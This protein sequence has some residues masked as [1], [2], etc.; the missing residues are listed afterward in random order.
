VKCDFASANPFSPAGRR[1]RSRELGLQGR[2]SKRA[3]RP[4]GRAASEEGHRLVAGY[5]HGVGDG[6]GGGR[7]RLSP[8]AGGRG[9]TPSVD[10]GGM[11]SMSSERSG[12]IGGGERAQGFD[13]KV[14]AVWIIALAVAVLVRP[15]ELN[16]L[17][18]LPFIL[19]LVLLSIYLASRTVAGMRSVFVPFSIVVT[20]TWFI[21]TTEWSGVRVLSVAESLVIVCIAGTASFVASFC[22]LR[23]LVGGVMAGALAVF[24]ASVAVAVAFPGYGLVSGDYQAGSLKGV[25]L[26]RNSLSFVLVLGLTATLAFDFRGRSARARRVI[27]VALFFGGVL[28]TSSSTCLVLAVVAVVLAAAL[29]LLRKVPPSRRGWALAAGASA[30]SAAVLYITDHTDD[31]LQLVD[32]DS[33]LTG[34]TQIWPV[35]QDIIST[36]PW[37]GQGWGAVWGEV[38]LHQQI[39]RSVGFAVAHSHNGYLD[40]QVQ[41]GAVGLALLLLVLLLVAVRGVADYLKSDSSLS[42]WAPIL[43]V[44]LLVYNRV[45]TSFSAPSTIFLIFATLVVLGRMKRT[46]AGVVRSVQRTAD[47]VSMEPRP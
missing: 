17:R 35:V 2:R 39:N 19:P 7:H 44:V 18:L 37:L 46:S 3:D 27:L 34:R 6:E 38:P 31:L 13:N 11:Q 36:R 33:T 24:V 14:N 9:E 42:S 30:A 8:G 47:V 1:A 16:F 4:R 12:G 26:D 5:A 22:S 10:A 32:R 20:V 43:T 45:E 21:T 41:V 29:D 15:R 28:W 25:M 40:V 23:E